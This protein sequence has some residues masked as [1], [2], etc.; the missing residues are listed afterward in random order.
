MKNNKYGY[1]ITKTGELEHRKLYKEHYG[2]IPKKYIIHHIDCIKT[3]NSIYNLIALPKRLHEIIHTKIKNQKRIIPREEIEILLNNYKTRL[4]LYY[5][6]RLR[7]ESELNKTNEIIEVLENDLLG[8]ENILNNEE[9]EKI[10]KKQF[11]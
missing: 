8:K 11:S 10:F 4:Q 9:I 5:K 2:E 6:K 1:K 7:L 3:N